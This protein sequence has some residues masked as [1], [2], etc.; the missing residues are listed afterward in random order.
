[1]RVKYPIR[2]PWCVSGN[3]ISLFFIKLYKVRFVRFFFLFGYKYL[4][5]LLSKNANRK[6]LI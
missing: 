4:G 1:M 6:C 2:M 3:N 5:Y